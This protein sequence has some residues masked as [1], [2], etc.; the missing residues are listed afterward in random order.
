M[1]GARA[2][3]R[4]AA[5][6]AT[7]RAHGG[8]G[9][10]A[11]VQAEG[12]R[13]RARGDGGSR[14]RAAAVGAVGGAL[15]ACAGMGGAVF[16]VP[17][18]VRFCGLAQPAAAGTAMTAVVAVSATAA[19]VHVAEGGGG[20]GEGVVGAGAGGVCWPVAAL[21]A[22]P[23]CATTPFGARLAPRVNP[24]LL[25]R[26]LGTFLLLL[27]PAM[28]MRAALARRRTERAEAADAA[29]VTAEMAHGATEDAGQEL[30]LPVRGGLV[31]GGAGIGFAA[32]MLGV[33]GGSLMTPLIA[34][35][36]PAA[37]MPAVLGTS[38]AAMLPP[39][40]VA[41][42]AYARLG[43]VRRR[44]VPPL[45]AGAAVGAAAGSQAVLAA[46][47]DA[48]RWAFAAVFAVMGARIVRSPL[49]KAVVKRAPR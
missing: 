18:L 14:A 34:V 27:A 32:G 4:A 41:A 48:L 43:L 22:V 31:A 21:L 42:A 25:R 13:P 6:L 5:R 23:A 16:M 7:R 36:L 49:G 11:E 29:G 44:L 26:G 9:G 15:G 2:R 24:A 37:S 46:P 38:F 17:G 12:Q 47:E 8:G 35:L 33:G 30:T 28:P 1:L 40:L 10:G 45:V 3:W 19:A 20:E 39:S